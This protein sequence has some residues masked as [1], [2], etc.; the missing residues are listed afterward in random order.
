MYAE[1]AADADFTAVGSALSSIYREISFEDFR[2]GHYFHYIPANVDRCKPTPALVF[3]HG[4]GGNFKAYIWL[5]TKM[6]DELGITV[7]APSFGMGNWEKRGGYETITRAIED[8][9]KH[10]AIDPDQIH[11]MGLSNGGKGL[12]LAESAAG[13]KFRSLIFL[14]AVWHNRIRPRELAAR[15][16]Q[17]RILILSGGSDPA[18]LN[19]VQCMFVP[20][21]FTGEDEI[22]DGPEQG[23][24]FASRPFCVA[25]IVHE[26]GAGTAKPNAIALAGDSDAD[27]LAA[28]PPVPG[29]TENDVLAALQHLDREMAYSEYIKVGY[30]IKHQFGE[31]GLDLFD[32]FFSTS[33]KYDAQETAKYWEGLNCKRRTIRALFRDALKAGWDGVLESGDTWLP[34]GGTLAVATLVQPV[35]LSASLAPVKPFDPAWLPSPFRRWVADIAERMQCPPEFPAV[36][37]M[38]ALSSVAGRRFCIQPKQHDEGYIEFAHLWAMLIGNPSLMK[39]PSMQAAMRPLRAMEKEAFRVFDELEY[40]RKA[41][42]IEAKIKRSTL[43][44]EAK[45]AAKAGAPFD[46]ASLIGEDGESS[47]CRRFIVN[48]AS[49]EAL[50]EVLKVNQTGTLLYQDELAGLLAMLD[51]DGNQDLRT[52]LLQ[53]WSGKEGFTFDRIGRGTRRIEACALSVLGSIQP[54][55]IAHHVLAANGTSAGADGF[56]QRFSLMVWPDI[57][58]SWK[59]IDRPLDQQAEETAAATFR[60]LENMTPEALLDMGAKSGRDGI[61]TFQFAQDAQKRFS[62]WREV[63]EHRLRSGTMAPAFEAHLGKY[64]KLVPALAVLIHVAEGQPGSVALS[65]LE[66]ALSFADCLESHAARL[67]GSGVMAECDAAKALLQKLRAG[68]TGLPDKFTAREVKR[69][70]WTHLTRSEEVEAACELLVDHHWLIATPQPTTGTGGRPTMFYTLNPLA[71]K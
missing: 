43:E 32:G 33:T 26:E 61:P 53:A 40:D 47:P 54:G 24:F 11:L 4:S 41:A 18:S 7:I 21:I 30:S 46:Y 51:K 42:E 20:C 64:R 25:D 48:N 37:A 23:S 52:F 55:V 17:R 15:F 19:P 16:Q 22:L 66:R 1:M 5:L 39:S 70:G 35:P 34:K 9:G 3:L 38:V 49:I 60:T 45:K 59:D 62:E 6:A 58:P 50:G 69:R 71:K 65:A 29:I 67:Y 36:A 8:A 28:G 63:L 68:D 44:S 31:A 13:P 10:A 27:L 2:D 57:N 56:M 14:S 12:C